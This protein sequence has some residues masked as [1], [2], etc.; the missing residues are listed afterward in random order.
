MLSKP[1]CGWTRIS[2]GDFEDQASYLT[3]VPLDTLDS[4]IS[5][6]RDYKRV[7]IF[8]DAEGC[9]YIIVPDFC[10]TYIIHNADESKL[11]V[12]DRNIY[13]I[14][15]EVIEDIERDIDGWAWWDVYDEEDTEEPLKRKNA[16]EE[17][18]AQLKLLLDKRHERNQLDQ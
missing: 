16:I 1:S 15:R 11:F 13:D 12:V 6:F 9:D 8:C 17:K 14:A 5:Y 3:D 4:F 18:L 2:L 7:G 10:E